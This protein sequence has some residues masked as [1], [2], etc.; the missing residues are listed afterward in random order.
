MYGIKT[1]E[2]LR[3][4]LVTSI[5]KAKNEGYKLDMNAYHC[6]SCLCVIGSAVHFSGEAYNVFNN[7]C[8][9][10]WDFCNGLMYGAACSIFD[11]SYRC[12]ASYA[13]ELS[14]EDHPHLTEETNLDHAIDYINLLFSKL[15]K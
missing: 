1:R 4:H 10:F 5:E 2:D 7:E 11:V 3:K 8:N 15:D 9:R 6:G 14:I 12:R 13:K